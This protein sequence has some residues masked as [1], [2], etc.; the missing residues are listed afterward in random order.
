MIIT[1]TS[2]IQGRTIKYY[3]GIVFGEIILGTNFIKDFKASFT[4][5]FGGRSKAYEDDLVRARTQA[6]H[7]LEMRAAEVGANA[8]VGVD[9]KY[10]GIG[11]GSTTMLMVTA[12]GTAVSVS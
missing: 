6:L 12:S 7:D 10:E 2:E 5:F 8:V 11:Q 9:I 3:K 1:T 4:N